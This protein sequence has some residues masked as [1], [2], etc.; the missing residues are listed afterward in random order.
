MSY[1][2]ALCWNC[3]TAANVV[4]ENGEAKEL[5]CPQCGETEDYN[6][7]LKVV[8]STMAARVQDMFRDAFKG[9]KYVTYKPG[10]I[11]RPRGKFRL[12]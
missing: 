8:S 12:G 7:F 4:L 1:Q 9:S 3:N 5:V 6:A 2:S 11:D 10:R